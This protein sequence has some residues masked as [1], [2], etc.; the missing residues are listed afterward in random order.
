MLQNEIIHGS[1]SAAAAVQSHPYLR[2]HRKKMHY[3]WVICIACTLMMYCNSG[4]TEGMFSVYAPFI[5]EKY[6]ISNTQL[7][8]L[9]TVKSVSSLLAVIFSGIYYKR[10]SLRIGGL[11]ARCV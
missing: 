11:A 1:V 4:I 5:L 9:M 2:I 7:S 10:Y 3:A 8:L 6:S